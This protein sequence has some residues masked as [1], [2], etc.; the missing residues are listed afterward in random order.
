MGR[1][2]GR[3][4]QRRTAAGAA[5]GWCCAALIAGTIAAAMC[6]PA[7]AQTPRVRLAAPA[8]CPRNTNCVPALRRV[9]RID[10]TSQ[11][12]RL[13]VADAG[14]QALDDGA[15]EVAVAFTSNP[16]LSRPDI[17]TLRD[18]R[19]MIT[20]DHVVPVV[21]TSLLERYG[22]ALRRRLNAASRL[23]TTL[24]LRGLTQQVIDGRQPEAVAGDFVDANALGGEP[25]RRRKGP[26]SSSASRTSPRTRCS[27]TCT[28]RRCA[29]PGSA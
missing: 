26:G 18:D 2:S 14:V 12:V 28:P 20:P 7:N 10:P 11:L 15:A 8:D 22:P 4:R 6:A 17:V 5:P 19:H 16:Q 25:T 21:R 23:L 24:R 29:G 9:Y 3:R 27:P 13:A 1:V